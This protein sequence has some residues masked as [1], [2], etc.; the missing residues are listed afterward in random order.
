MPWYVKYCHF[1]F[2]YST[3]G[4]Y[5]FKNHRRTVVITQ[6]NNNYCEDILTC[7]ASWKFVVKQLSL[8]EE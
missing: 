1:L 3:T 4:S 2:D 7:L 6:R 5:Y 8:Q